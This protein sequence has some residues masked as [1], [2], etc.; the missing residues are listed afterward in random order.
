MIALPELSRSAIAKD[1]P[2]LK[3]FAEGFAVCI[4]GPKLNTA[5]Q[6]FLRI[7]RIGRGKVFKRCLQ[8]LDLE[9][10]VS[11]SD[12]FELSN[13]SIARAFSGSPTASADEESAHLL[14]LDEAQRL[15]PYSVY[16]ILRPLTA[17]TGG[18]IWNLGTPGLTRCPFL[19]DIRYNQQHEPHLDQQVNY[20]EV[21][22]YST[23]YQRYIEEELKRLPGGKENEF[24]KMNFLLEW[25]L[26]EGH[27][28]DPDNFE[29]LK[30]NF[31]RGT[32]TGGRLTAGIDWGKV[33]S[34]TVVTILEERN[35][36]GKPDYVAIDW[37]DLKGDN[38][39]NQYQYIE[40]FLA[41][42]ENPLTYSESR[43][44]G[45][46]ATEQMQKRLGSKVIV[47]KC[48]TGV[49]NDR[50]HSNLGN[51]CKIGQFGYCADSSSE[52]KAFEEQM[53]NAVKETKA[54]LL[55]VH[56]A[57]S[58]EEYAVGDDFI[59]CYDNST[60]VLTSSGW[61]KFQEIQV[62]ELIPSLNLS[63]FQ[64]EFVPNLETIEK[65]YKG[66]M[67]EFSGRN[68]YLLVTP[69]HNMVAALSKGANKYYP[70]RLTRAK[71]LIG[72]HFRLKRNAK[73]AGKYL[74]FWEIP[75]YRY[76]F[77]RRKRLEK[78]PVQFFPIKAFL[79]F[80]G[81]Y[82]SE[83]CAKN[84][85]IQLAQSAQGK[86]YSEIQATLDELNLK[87]SVDSKGFHVCNRQLCDYIRF[88]VPG[89]ATEKRIPPSVLELFPDLL[90]YL[91]D[92]MVLGD[93]SFSGNCIYYTTSS[94]GLKDDFLVLVNKIGL[95][96]TVKCHNGVENVQI[97][98]HNSSRKP[99]YTI[100]VS[101]S[102]LA[103]RF[104][105]LKGA[106]NRATCKYLDY[107]GTIVCLRLPKNHTL[108]VRR[109]GKMCWS[110]NSAALALDAALSEPDREISFASTGQRRSCANKM[111]DF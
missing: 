42:Y 31:K 8:E 71:D 64:V 82:I 68:I 16:K 17:A 97:C 76:N 7:K 66:K 80:L 15:S 49:Y 11:N 12:T 108:M 4:S 88:L 28:I 27:F 65:N 30:R 89:H 40:H 75:A 44:E 6:I 72:R 100:S 1:F 101:K 107:S 45:S 53:L 38:Y 98:G 13:G 96:A 55:C 87:Y 21:E 35:G 5:R 22:K 60:E 79:K 2:R 86:A 46:P 18:L 26:A 63:T 52:S 59:D 77:K 69:N 10:T 105:Y 37:L 25:L 90:K 50:I 74:D 33:D 109:N 62:S 36:S 34:A 70:F 103:P 14:I 85:L 110:G 3:E 102:C 9:V 104:N 67:V 47:G 23:A 58:Q 111:S 81:F 57:D 29:I 19:R 91:F 73:W 20:L 41:G 51:F 78:K 48:P 95:S 84:T 39:E 32:Q 94:P 54:G 92:S 43:G 99:R 56:K 106:K 24:F 93:G 61:K 83:G